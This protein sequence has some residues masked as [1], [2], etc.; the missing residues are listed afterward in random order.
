MAENKDENWSLFDSCIAVIVGSVDLLR[1]GSMILPKNIAQYILFEAC[2][3]KNF[4]AVE[5]VVGSWPHSE[6]SFDFMLNK[7]CRRCKELSKSCYEAHDYYNAHSTD[8]YADC[9][10]SIALGLFNNLHTNLKQTD[11]SLIKKVDLSKIRV[12]EHTKG[13]YFIPKSTLNL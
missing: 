10:P 6:L 7:F 2:N 4:T 9:I 12:A 8:H 1:K 5:A 13:G 3:A 11:T